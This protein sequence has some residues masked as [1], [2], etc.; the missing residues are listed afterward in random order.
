MSDRPEP[1]R[2]LRVAPSPARARA[3]GTR[4]TVLLALSV[5]AGSTGLAAASV[6]LYRLFCQLT[7]YGGTTQRAAQA[8]EAGAGPTLTVY[9]NADTALDLPWKFRPQARSMK[10]VPGE[11]QLAFY[12]ARN[13]ADGPVVGRAVYNVT[14]HKV[15]PYFAKIACFCFDEQTLEP[16]ERVEMPVS[17][18]VDPEI[19]NDA[20]TSDVRQITL[21]YTFFIDAEAT[22]ALREQRAQQA[23]APSA[24]AAPNG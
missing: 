3:R 13:L 15:G 24:R 23:H 2:D 21:S 5:I 12:E 17:V 10:V 20:S 14:P 1:D 6:P 7:G 18:F 4:A 9:F 19:A 16:G 8:P 11:Q 22:K